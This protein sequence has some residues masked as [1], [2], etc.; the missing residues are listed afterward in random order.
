[1]EILGHADISTTLGIY[2]QVAREMA[3]EAAHKIAAALWE[4]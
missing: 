3:A 4:S 2:T 1:M